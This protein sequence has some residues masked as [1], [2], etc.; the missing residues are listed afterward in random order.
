MAD[1][2][3]ELEEIRNFYDKTDMSDLILKGEDVTGFTK[4]E[5][6]EWQKNKKKMKLISVRLPESLIEKMKNKA[7]KMGIGYQTLIRIIL[8]KEIEN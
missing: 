2:L 1:K 5:V 8:M 3:K 7:Y 6:K 4:E